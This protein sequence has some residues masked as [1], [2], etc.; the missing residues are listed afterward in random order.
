MDSGHKIAFID[1]IAAVIK[2]PVS[3]VVVLNSTGVSRRLS[4]VFYSIERVRITAS[5]SAYS[6]RDE[7]ST[8]FLQFLSSMITSAVYSGQAT[9]IFRSKLSSMHI[10]DVSEPAIVAYVAGDFVSSPT[11]S[12]SILIQ[13]DSSSAGNA[14]SSVNMALVAGVVAGLVGLLCAATPVVM[15]FRRE[16]KKKEEKGDSK[17]NSIVEDIVCDINTDG[18]PLGD[19]SLAKSGI[20]ESRDSPNSRLSIRLSKVSKSRSEE[21]E[22]YNKRLTMDHNDFP[23][24]VLPKAAVSMIKED[25][26]TVDKPAPFSAYYDLCAEKG[27]NNSST[28]ASSNGNNANNNVDDRMSSFYGKDKVEQ[29]FVNPLKFSRIGSSVSRS[30]FIVPDFT[31]SSGQVPASTSTL[32][33]ISDFYPQ[34]QKEDE[35][36]IRNIGGQEDTLKFSKFLVQHNDVED[37]SRTDIPVESFATSRKETLPIIFNTEEIISSESQR[38]PG[39]YEIVESVGDLFKTYKNNSNISI[40]D[41]Y[42]MNSPPRS[43]KPELTHAATEPP[44]GMRSSVHRGPS[45][46]RPSALHQSNDSEDSAANVNVDAHLPHSQRFKAIKMKFETMIQKNTKTLLL[47]PKESKS[48]L[49]SASSDREVYSI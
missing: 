27:S 19:I 43:P 10:V 41:I 9:E 14:K 42:P 31:E 47:T 11:K 6:I 26:Q 7:N 29:H 15:Y 3:D 28:D 23:P 22:Y 45:L 38:V 20:K 33:G 36:D 37:L 18:M 16:S 35:Q 48:R 32:F 40:Y 39:K 1:T 46:A 4:T 30:S 8:L 25:S 49:K 21:S 34:T 44:A 5:E 12:P 13:S 24:Q 17:G 2:L